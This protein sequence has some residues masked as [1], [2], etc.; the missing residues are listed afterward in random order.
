MFRA[1]A[2]AGSTV[3]DDEQLGNAD[4]SEDEPPRLGHIGGFIGL[5]R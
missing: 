4:D 3:E 1:Y 5:T 2:A